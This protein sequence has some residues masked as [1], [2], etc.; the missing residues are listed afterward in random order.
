MPVAGEDGVYV[1]RLPF[2]RR[3]A[4][5][6]AIHSA[7]P[8][9]KRT[10]ST[11]KAAAKRM[12]AITQW[13]EHD[14]AAMAQPD[15]LS[16]TRRRAHRSLGSAFALIQPPGTAAC[17]RVRSPGAPKTP[18]L[19]DWPP[20]PPEPRARRVAPGTHV[21]R[22]LGLCRSLGAWPGAAHS[23]PRSSRCVA[24]AQSNGCGV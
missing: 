24:A 20:A 5:L 11:G 2:G 23:N 18:D 7:A 4:M 1:A 22:P 8:W 13:K 16:Q 19:R 10:R 15:P 21:P 9:L 6:P 3:L 12:A 14:K 17:A